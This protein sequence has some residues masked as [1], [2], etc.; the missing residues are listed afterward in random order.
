MTATRRSA[1]PIPTVDDRNGLGGAAEARQ[2][3]SRQR[4]IPRGRLSAIIV[5]YAVTGTSQ[6][7]IEQQ[8]ERIS[9]VRHLAGLVIDGDHVNR[10]DHVTPRM[11]TRYWTYR[12]G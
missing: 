10:H 5:S 2:P 7:A 4:R 12:N 9:Q 3:W 11:R 1:R 6:T 8:R